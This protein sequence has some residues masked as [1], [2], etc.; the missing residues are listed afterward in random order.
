MGFVEV[1]CKIR[2]SDEEVWNK[3]FLKRKKKNS[4][5]MVYLIFSL[6][7]LVRPQLTSLSLGQVIRGKLLRLD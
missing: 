7:F 2:I 1:V 5:R 4:N 3:L 6:E